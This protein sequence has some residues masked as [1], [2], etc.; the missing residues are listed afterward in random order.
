MTAGSPTQLDRSSLVDPPISHPRSRMTGWAAY[1]TAAGG[2]MVGL[3]SRSD[4]KR[5]CPR[6]QADLSNR[7]V[8]PPNDQYVPA[9]NQ[10]CLPAQWPYVPAFDQGGLPAQCSVST[11]HQSGR[12]SCPMTD[13]HRPSTRDVS[14]PNGRYRPLIREVSPPNRRE[15]AIQLYQGA[16]VL[17]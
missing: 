6:R 11:G 8:S 12:T 4:S 17:L 3:P 13:M 14:L 2:G 1:L 5:T 10:G 7:E 16:A 9:I 15:A